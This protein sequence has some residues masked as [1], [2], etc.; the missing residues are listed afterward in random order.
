MG[1]R[2]AGARRQAAREGEVADVLLLAACG[3]AAVAPDYNGRTAL[4]LAA[5][6]GRSLSVYAL[7]CRSPHLYGTC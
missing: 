3:A 2:Q 7:L 5:A 6:E 1:W 4:H